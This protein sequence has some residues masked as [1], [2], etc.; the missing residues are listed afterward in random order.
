MVEIVFPLKN[1]VVDTTRKFAQEIL[2]HPL[3][4][5]QKHG[6]E[7]LEIVRDTPVMLPYAFHT[8]HG[9]VLV[10]A[11]ALLESGINSFA[12]P[13]AA[14]YWF[15]DPKMVA[16]AN[17]F[18]PVFP[19]PRPSKAKAEEN[20]LAGVK[21]AMKLQIDLIQK[22]GLSLLLA[23]EGTRT[24]LPPEER[25]FMPG[26]AFLAIETGV[27]IVP[28]TV[29]GYETVY[30]KGTAIPRPYDF[31]NQGFDKRKRVDVIFG[32]PLDSTGV[33]NNSQ[34]RQML[35]D[36]VKNVVIQTYYQYAKRLK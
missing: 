3:F 18:T 30:P 2:L 13:G 32:E 23:V 29:V 26:C 36:R 33:K 11:H 21:D 22:R 6:L 10:V 15:K 20:P 7:N 25:K 8:G 31:H 28:V 4:N 9:D 17:L 35:T 24:D 34:N 16:L 27:P 14:D 1:R 5:I 12:V 19:L